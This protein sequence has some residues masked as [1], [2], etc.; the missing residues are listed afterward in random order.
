MAKLMFLGIAT[1][2][3]ASASNATAQQ[4]RGVGCTST[5]QCSSVNASSERNC[6]CEPQC[7]PSGC[8]ACLQSCTLNCAYA[9]PQC[10]SP[11][12][13]SG[14]IAAGAVFTVSPEWI[15]S[16]STA[17][18]VAGIVLQGRSQGGR[19]PL[20]SEVV[21]GGTNIF[22]E[23][24]GFTVNMA[25]DQNGVALDIAF[26]R[27]AHRI[28]TPESVTF[29]MDAAGNITVSPLSPEAR[30]RLEQGLAVSS[31]PCETVLAAALRPVY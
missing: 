21:S 1:I 15:A 22:G 20:Y 27:E 25:A 5:N 12:C 29:R 3:V 28:P 17:N 10:G 11:L 18:A 6:C 16:A 2:L 13:G 8:Y 7:G 31:V 26:N 19:V 24:V 9:C 30:A 14:A 4:C 23:Q